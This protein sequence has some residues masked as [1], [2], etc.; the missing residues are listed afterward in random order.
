MKPLSEDM[1]YRR[2]L[3]TSWGKIAILKAQHDLKSD[4]EKKKKKKKEKEK[5]KRN[6]K[7]Q[8]EAYWRTR[9]RSQQTE[10]SVKVLCAMRHEEDR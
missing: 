8:G 7:W 5:E 1:T 10:K 3:V 4:S 2:L 6:G 9:G